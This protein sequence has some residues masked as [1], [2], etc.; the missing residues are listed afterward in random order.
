MAEQLTAGNM[1]EVV[2]AYLW[3]VVVY[4]DGKILIEVD[5]EDSI[6]L[7]RL[8]HDTAVARGAQRVVAQV[9]HYDGR[10]DQRF[11]VDVMWEFLEAGGQPVA[12]GE[13]RYFCRLD[14]DSVGVEMIEYRQ[15]PF[16]DLTGDAP[17]PR[18]RH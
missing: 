4:L 5:R 11:S 17:G 16:P 7:I 12:S 15:S 2:Q 6:R 13:I 8:I 9:L 10:L 18:Q 3:P 14:G 1:A